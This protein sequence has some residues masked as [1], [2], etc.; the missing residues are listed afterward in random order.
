MINTVILWIMAAGAVLGGIDLLLGNKLGLGSQFEEGFHLLGRLALAQAGIICLAPALGKLL[1][2]SSAPLWA[3]LGLDPGMLGSVLAID[4]GGY[5]LAM[6]LARDALIGRFSGIVAASMLG[7]TLVFTIPVG[8]GFLPKESQAAFAQG[9]LCGMIVLPFA[10]FFGALLCRIPVLTALANC[11][12]ALLLGILCG[13][14]IFRHRDAAIRFFKGFAKFIRICGILGLILGAVQYM[15]GLKI[16]PALAPLEEAM[17]VISGIGILLL[18][19][20][21]VA[22]LL[23]RA[24]TRPLSGLAGKLSVSPAAALNLLIGCIS[25]TLGLAALRGMKDREIRLNAAFYSCMASALAVHIAFALNEEPSMAVPVLIAEL[26]GGVA[27][28]L[29]ALRWKEA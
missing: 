29:I 12:P 9:T 18:G 4:M 17:E 21:P 11:L 20:L 7:C 13:W 24:L 16:L 6:E 3:K 8:M 5:P 14:A 15:T 28:V 22:E 27:A 1:S 25:E 26:A 2:V 23:R 10:M 19:A